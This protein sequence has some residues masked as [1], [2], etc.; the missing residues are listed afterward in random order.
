[1]AGQYGQFPKLQKQLQ[2]SQI[3]VLT[4]DTKMIADP[5]IPSRMPS[6]VF[7]PRRSGALIDVLLFLLDI[8]AGISLCWSRFRIARRYRDT[9][10]A[11][12][13]A[14]SG[15]AMGDLL[16]TVTVCPSIAIVTNYGISLVL[17]FD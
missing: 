14:S 11:F 7:E 15:L 17:I 8:A 1:M 6:S 12:C 5:A 16:S 13:A 2:L 10:S 4:P 9:A 3:R